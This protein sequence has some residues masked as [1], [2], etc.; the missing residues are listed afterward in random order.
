MLTHTDGVL[1]ES[2]IERVAR[3][4]LERYPKMQIADLF[5]L[6]Y[7]HEFGAE[8]LIADA[9]QSRQR[10]E[11]EADHLLAVALEGEVVEAIGNG[12]VRVYLRIIKRDG[13]T[14]ESL[15]R[16]FLQTASR[17]RGNQAGFEHKAELLLQMICRKELAFDPE[18]FREFL[19]DH[20]RRGSPAIRHSP[21][22][23]ELYAP[24]YRVV[25]QSLAERLI[26][27]EEIAR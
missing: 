7:Q 10:I 19:L 15:N 13:I 26:H 12:L 22:Y 3:D 2:E 17:S 5:K 6:L 9:E 20:C 18:E 14:S 25:E 11:E 1:G 21:S 16:A 27:G 23:R 4:H 24:A 8:H